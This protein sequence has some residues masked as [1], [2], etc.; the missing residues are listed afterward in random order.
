MD[1]AVLHEWGTPVFGAFEDPVAAD[2]Q[3]LV[4]VE[5]AAVNPVDLLIASGQFYIRPDRLPYVV[6]T[7]GVGRLADGRRVYFGATAAPFGAAAQRALA[8]EA[9]LIELSDGVDAAVAATLGNTGL[10]A[11]LSLQWRAEVAAGETVMVLGATGAVGRLAV[12]AAKL[13]GAG[14]VIA[15]G[16]DPD[17]LRRAVELGADDTLELTDLDS[18]AEATVDVIVDLLWGAP[19]ATALQWAATGARLVQIGQPAGPESPLPAALLRS[20]RIDVLGFANYHA[21][22][23]LRASTYGRLVDLAAT[24]TLVVDV[25]TIPLADVADAWR[26]QRAGAGHKLVL[27]PQP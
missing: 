14:R 24:G 26:R 7:D 18:G 13:L 25:E 2:G 9:V 27:V 10:A 6:G 22:A 17:G 12:Q 3:V 8:P 5:A 23:D 20:R 15:V 11:W 16:R 21:P 4:D 19:A 1:A